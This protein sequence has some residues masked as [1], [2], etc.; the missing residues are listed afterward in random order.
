MCAKSL[1]CALYMLLCSSIFILRA[2]A[3]ET[4][5]DDAGAG[6]LGNDT[7]EDLEQRMQRMKQLA[8]MVGLF[9]CMHSQCSRVFKARSGL[10]RH[11]QASGHFTYSVPLQELQLK[12]RHRYTFREKRAMILDVLAWARKEGGDEYKGRCHVSQRTGVCTDLLCRWMKQR[13][14][15]FR[16]ANTRGRGGSWSYVEKFG[17]W[18]EQEI[19]LYIKFIYR[20]RYQGLRV[21][22][23]WLQRTFK[24]TRAEAGH[25]VD[26]WFPSQGWC[27]RFCKRWDITS[28]C[29]T[30]KKK[31]S[32]EERLPKIQGFH[33]YWILSVQSTGEQ[34][35]PKYGRYPPSHIFTMDQVPMPFSSPSKRSMNEKGAPRGNR[36]TAASEDDKR[37]CT[38][39]VTLCA[40]NTDNDVPIELIFASTSG[41]EKMS[42]EEKDFYKEYPN[43]KVRWQPKAWA[44]EPICID[45]I[46]D[47]REHTVDKGPIALIMDNHSAQSTPR[48]Q[49]IMT[50]FDINYVYTPAGCTDCVSPIDRNVGHWLKERVYQY[51]DDELELPENR[52][53]ALPSKH[54]GLT[55]KEKRMHVVRWM[56][57]AWEDLKRERPELL[58]AAWVQSGCLVAKDGSE[59]HLIKLY[60]QQP[61]GAYNY[62]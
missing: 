37:F 5:W 49:N 21:T 59:N 50:H 46:V 7:Y 20:R 4:N 44:D 13:E 2:N 51:Q 15:I 45:Y 43:V 61:E 8:S 32:I 14:S 57:Q 23:K 16:H 33:Q 62:I 29:R 42:Q 26:G 31:Y 52:N 11:Y 56:S 41:G 55:K 54:G 28:Q 10:E 48:L 19:Q 12:R 47:L 38:I 60:P 35:C 58:T 53:W 1:S 39:Q 27:T 30:N 6:S 3:M 25:N 18:H 9:V 40:D 36:F 34:R 22:R 17:E 24:F